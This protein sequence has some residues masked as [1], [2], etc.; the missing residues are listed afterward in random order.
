MERMNQVLLLSVVAVLLGTTKVPA[1]NLALRDG[2]QIV[3]TLQEGGRIHWRRGSREDVGIR[4]RDGLTGSSTSV[5]LWVRPLSLIAHQGVGYYFGGTARDVTEIEIVEN[6][7]RTVRATV[8]YDG[9]S[10]EFG[11]LTPA[12]VGDHSTILRLDR[13]VDTR[14]VYIVVSEIESGGNRNDIVDIRELRVEGREITPAALEHV[15]HR[16]R[17][18]HWRFIGPDFVHNRATIA[19]ATETQRYTN[20]YNSANLMGGADSLDLDQQRRAEQ[21]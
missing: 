11:P 5:L 4:I 20:A 2:V 7:Q 10:Q 17:G 18:S 9:G 3:G 12:G 14:F 1:E 16:T 8:Y 21:R 19:S 13:P 6:F 15:V